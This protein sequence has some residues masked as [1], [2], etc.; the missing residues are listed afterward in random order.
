MCVRASGFTPSPH[1]A[2]L[3]LHRCARAYEARVFYDAGIERVLCRILKL[4]P[5]PPPASAAR[6]R[7]YIEQTRLNSPAFGYCV[8][9]RLVGIAHIYTRAICIPKLYTLH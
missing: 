2:R 7:G 6:A 4:P 5:P 3:C 9:L 1:P 8:K